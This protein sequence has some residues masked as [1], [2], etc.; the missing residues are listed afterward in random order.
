MA[1]TPAGHVTEVV[2]MRE[3]E[4]TA[5]G[6]AQLEFPEP[7][8]PALTLAAV[9]TAVP[10]ARLFTTHCLRRL[11]IRG[12]LADTAEI[13]VSELVTNAV[14]AT[15]TTR[16]L[17]ALAVLNTR[18]SLINV[19]LRLTST[20]LFIEV[21]DRDNQPPLLGQ[22]APD[23]ESGRGLLLVAGL[24]KQWGYC[25]T[26]QGGKVVWC[27]LDRAGSTGCPQGGAE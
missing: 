5:V 6:C 23:Q 19:S 4:P 1:A 14:K 27:E 15:G 18:L 25:P 16:R 10:C 17:S 2:E 24:S 8:V 26:D 13:I 20:S 7:V 9:A 11:G 3:P 22:P 21:W 12:D